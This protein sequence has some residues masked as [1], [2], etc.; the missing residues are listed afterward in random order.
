MY[1]RLFPATKGYVEPP[2]GHIV[3][4]KARV[5]SER[6]EKKERTENCLEKSQ[7]LDP[8]LRGPQTA[9]KQKGIEDKCSGHL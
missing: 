5:Y 7:P 9:N 6:N 3:F 4:Q 8:E 1:T 2:R